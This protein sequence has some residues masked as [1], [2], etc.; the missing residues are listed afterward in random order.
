MSKG[1]NHIVG[2]KSWHFHH[3]HTIGS[4]KIFNHGNSPSDVFRSFIACGFVLRKLFVTKSAAWR[5]E[6]D[7][8]E[9]RIFLAEQFFEGID[10]TESGWGILTFAVDAW[11]T[12]ESVI[13]SKNQCISIEKH[14]FLHISNSLNFKSTQKNW[15]TA[16]FFVFLSDNS[17]N[18]LA[19]TFPSLGEVWTFS[20]QILLDACQYDR[21]WPHQTS[22]TCRTWTL[23]CTVRRGSHARWRFYESS[24]LLCAQ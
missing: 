22:Y 24:A 8:H 14:E 15:V 10:K 17:T 3:S 7:R 21:T 13:G 5:I 1:A 16:L 20:S 11:R 19:F 2:F 12:N 9:V 6:G 23:R 4:Q 18:P